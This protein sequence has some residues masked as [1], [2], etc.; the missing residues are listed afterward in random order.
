[1]HTQRRELLPATQDLGEPLRQ[2]EVEGSQDRRDLV[3]W[4][5]Q[6]ETPDRKREERSRQ[7]KAVLPRS[8]V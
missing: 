3:L 2:A 4:L 7:W 8:L 1:M 6:Q 5:A